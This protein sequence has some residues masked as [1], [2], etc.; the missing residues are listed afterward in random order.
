MKKICGLAVMIW[1]VTL[2][3]AGQ[4]A[5]D[6]VGN[7]LA[8][9]GPILSRA[10]DA[11]SS[12]RTPDDVIGVLRLIEQA[13]EKAPNWSEV[14]YML[15]I[16]H[17]TAQHYDAAIEAF[18][19]FL[20]LA[21]DSPDAPRVRSLRDDA[22]AKRSTEAG[23]QVTMNM[24]RADALMDQGRYREA[25]VE[26]DRFLADHPRSA[27]AMF[28]KGVCYS[29]LND[30]DNA[31]AAYL[32]VIDIDPGYKKVYTNLGNTYSHM[33]N[34]VEAEKA[35]Q[36]AILLDDSNFRPYFNLGNIYLEEGRFDKAYDQ[37]KKTVSL[38]PNYDIA[39]LN[40]S[41]ICFEL[42]RYSESAD[43]S[44]KA[45]QINPQN[46]MAETNLGVSL[47]KLGRNEEADRKSVV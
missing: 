34:R 36:R 16:V 45:L 41:K 8:G 29:S 27:A 33:R 24:I 22:A 23:T 12:A 44:R 4:V 17:H 26:Y 42:G 5:A 3:A 28:N 46:A 14:Y 20:S 39:Y 30:D 25:I 15:G 21:P 9:A 37:Y 19:T 40:L 35:Y 32:R 7:D 11:F 1:V 10:Q 13:R 18:N 47:R 43:W 2:M 6:Q 31:L 38:N